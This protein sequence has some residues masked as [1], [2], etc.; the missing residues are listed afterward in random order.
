VKSFSIPS[1][2]PTILNPRKINVFDGAELDSF[3]FSFDVFED[4]IVIGSFGDGQG[5]GSAY[6]YNEDGE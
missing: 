4:T 2:Q 6:L 1:S 3:G 5:S